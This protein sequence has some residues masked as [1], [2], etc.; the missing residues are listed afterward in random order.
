MHLS[1]LFGLLSF[2]HLQVKF[3]EYKRYNDTMYTLNV[4]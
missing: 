3:R 4:I 1:L 2:I